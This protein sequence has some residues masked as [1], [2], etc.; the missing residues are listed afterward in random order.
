M[1]KFY[2]GCGH[3]FQ[4]FSFLNILEADDTDIDKE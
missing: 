2:S 3:A 4:P 1:S